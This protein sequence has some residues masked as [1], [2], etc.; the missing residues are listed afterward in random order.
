MIKH[1]NTLT[2]DL[3]SEVRTS[4]TLNI[5]L[6]QEILLESIP[7]GTASHSLFKYEYLNHEML[8]KFPRAGYSDEFKKNAA[9]QLM[10]ESEEHCRSINIDGYRSTNT[11]GSTDNVIAVAAYVAQQ[12]LSPVDYSM[13]EKASFSGGSSTSRKRTNGHPYFK[14]HPHWR[15]DCTRS[16][17]PYA[18]SLIKMTPLWRDMLLK[19]ESPDQLHTYLRSRVGNDITTVPKKTKIDRCIA[20]EPDMNMCLQK[21]CGSYIRDRLQ[22]WGVNLNDQTVNQKFAKEGSLRRNYGTIDLKSASDSISIRI[23]KDILPNDWFKL[24]DDLRSRHGKLPDGTLIKWEKFS[25][26]GNGFTFELESLIFFCLAKAVQMIQGTKGSI[27]VYGDDIIAPSAMCRDLID[28][29]DCVG[30][31]TNNDKTFVH[32][33]FRES[34]G[35]HYYNGVDVSPFYIRSAV[36]TA[37]RFTWFLNKLREWALCDETQIMNEH[38]W[39]L[40]RKIYKAAIVAFPILK[41]VVGEIDIQSSD[42]IYSAHAFEDYQRLHLI[43]TSSPLRGVRGLLSVMQDWTV[44]N[45]SNRYMNSFHTIDYTEGTPRLVSPGSGHVDLVNR[46]PWLYSRYRHHLF[47]AEQKY[48]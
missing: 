28:V 23:V 18:E 3:C 30:F 21:A 25:S 39:P 14:Y 36:D 40:Y 34:C 24:L 1:I 47:D 42:G 38:I 9:I 41:K 31:K 33:R 7:E 27:V 32:G 8:S 17:M 10:L 43:T 22:L 26:M 2:A 4:K 45:V 35:K 5:D 11:T 15:V 13:F 37:H 19:G 48:S 20:K 16:A 46:D 6:L 29:L 44:R 12:I